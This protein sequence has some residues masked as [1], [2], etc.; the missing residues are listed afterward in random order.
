MASIAAARSIFRSTSVRSAA[1]KFAS[2]AKPASSPFRAPASNSLSQRIFRC[3]AELSVCLETMQ[4]LHT[5]TASALMTSM[6]SISP[7]CYGWVPDGC[8]KTR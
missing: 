7:R 3:P 5:A 4:P 1:S 6:L 8:I 2:G